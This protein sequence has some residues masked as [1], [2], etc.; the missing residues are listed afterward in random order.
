LHGSCATPRVGWDKIDWRRDNSCRPYTSAASVF[1]FKSTSPAIT[2]RTNKREPSSKSF[3]RHYGHRAGIED[4]G[5]ESPSFYR[6]CLGLGHRI[7]RC[8]HRHQEVSRRTA[9][10]K[11][12]SGRDCRSFIT[13]TDPALDWHHGCLLLLCWDG[14]RR[15]RMSTFAEKN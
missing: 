10:R 8:H 9:G 15:R 6:F 4:Y 1:L 3:H 7:T 13:L 14:Q 12:L 5:T 2:R 11:P